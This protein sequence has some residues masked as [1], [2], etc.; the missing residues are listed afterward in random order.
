ME[1]TLPKEVKFFVGCL[2]RSREKLSLAVKELENCFGKVDLESEEFPFDVTDYYEKEIGKGI[3]RRFFS[4]SGLF[5]PVYLSDAKLITNEIE[6][7]LAVNGRRS[8]NL[9]IGYIDFDK[10]VLASAKYCI[11]K[12]YIGHGI[13]ADMTLHYEKGKYFPYPW[14]FMD[15]KSER[16]H[17]FFLKM[18]EIYKRQM[19]KNRT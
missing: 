14:A 16:Y 6:K 10:V 12:I 7:K 3:K 2:Y 17:R 13:Y 8:V 15:F 9:D 4:F 1:I 5:N 19:K 11:H 18:R